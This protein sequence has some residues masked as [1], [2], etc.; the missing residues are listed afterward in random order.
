MAIDLF[1]GMRVR[2]LQTAVRWYSALLGSAESFRPNNEEAVWTVGEHG[3]VYVLVDAEHAGSGLLT[4]FTDD[5]DAALAT[6]ARG[7]IEP[8][9]LETYGNGVRK[10]TFHDPDGNEVGLGGGRTT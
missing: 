6:A 8:T 10:A 4:L 2:N 5:L 3:H 7:G 9:S 1:A